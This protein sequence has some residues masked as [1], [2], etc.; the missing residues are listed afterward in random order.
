MALRTP[1]AKSTGGFL[2]LNHYLTFTARGIRRQKVQKGPNRVQVR[3]L[4]L[5]SGSKE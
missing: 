5:E 1:S 3:E 2:K 4:I